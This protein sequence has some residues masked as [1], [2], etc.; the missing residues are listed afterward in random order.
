[1]FLILNPKMSKL[2]HSAALYAGGKVQMKV[3]YNKYYN[4]CILF[5][6]H[7]SENF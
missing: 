1:M 6:K 7:L 5:C 2:S 3:F 4:R